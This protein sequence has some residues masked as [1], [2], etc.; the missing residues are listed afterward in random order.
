[1]KEI[2]LEPMRGPPRAVGVKNVKIQENS[3]QI[4]DPLQPFRVPKKNLGTLE[5]KKCQNCLPRRGARPP[6]LPSRGARRPSL[7]I[8]TFFTY[9]GP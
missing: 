2:C 7:P 8:F 9:R 4:R 3:E 6:S 5:V 1:M